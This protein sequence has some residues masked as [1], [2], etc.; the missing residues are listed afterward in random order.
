MKTKLLGFLAV[1]L[2]AGPNASQAVTVTVG[3]NVWDVTST[4]VAFSSFTIP[5]PDMP[6]WGNSS[7]AAAF[8]SA[9]MN[10]SWLYATGIL[11]TSCPGSP[12]GFCYSVEG[13]FYGGGGGTGTFSAPDT[14]PGPYAQAKLV[15]APEPGTLALLG[16]GLAA[17]G[18]GRRRNC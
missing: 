7:L 10:G 3:G 9:V 5:P 16:L 15:A 13:A 1:A 18:L 11:A 8:A 17:L 14:E 12:T 6:W 2:L 4:S